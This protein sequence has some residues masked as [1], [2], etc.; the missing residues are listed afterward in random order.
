MIFIENCFLNVFFF[1]ESIAGEFTYVHSDTRA[2][3]YNNG[4][5]VL[6]DIEENDAGSYLCQASN[7][8]GAGL[9]KIITL[10]V[11]GKDLMYYLGYHTF[12][13]ILN[14]LHYSRLKVFRIKL[15]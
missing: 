1:S 9:S 12:S 7:G 11:L 2:H 15:T 10:D 6:S 14:K 13:K 5:L 4:T 8:I 3:R